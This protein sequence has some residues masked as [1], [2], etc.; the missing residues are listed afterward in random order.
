MLIYEELYNHFEKV[1]KGEIDFSFSLSPYRLSKDDY[2]KGM[3]EI[4]TNNL[5]CNRMC[6]IKINSDEKID[7]NEFNKILIFLLCGK[8]DNL[9][10][11]SLGTGVV[12]ED[13]F[14][15]EFFLKRADAL[16]ESEIFDKIMADAYKDS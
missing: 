2:E 14:D 8:I 10:R 9:Y 15:V 13:S 3:E 16:N 11:R 1:L 12:L 4:F 7:E 6:N 5:I